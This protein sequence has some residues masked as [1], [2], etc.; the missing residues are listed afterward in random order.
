VTVFQIAVL[1]M[2]AAIAGR[3]SKGRQLILL[4]ISV[5]AVFWLQD[6][7]P[8]PALRFW[9]PLAT[10][11]L[12]TLS[13]ALTATPDVRSWSQNWPAATVLAATVL[14]VAV[15]RHIPLDR[16]HVAGTPSLAAAILAVIALA[17]T[18]ALLIYWQKAAAQLRVVAIIG[19]IAALVV[20]KSPAVM[21]ALMAM[22]ANERALNLTG[23]A[24][25]IAWLGYSY[26]AFRLLHTIRDRQSGRLPP[27]SLSE[28]VNYAVFFPAFTS[29]P[30]DRAERFVPE[31]RCPLPL[32][33]EDWIYAV[34]RLMLGLFKK[35]VIADLLAVISISNALVSRV[36]FRGMLWLF[37]Y[38][39]AFRIY[40]DFSGYTDIA[41]GMG[42]LMGIQ[43]P[44]NFNSPYLK[45]NLT[46][47][48]NAWHITL[49]QWFRSYVFNPMTRYLRRWELPAWLII[50]ITQL[51]TMVLIGL[52][53]GITWGFAAWGLWHG[54]GLFIHNRW[55]EVSRN[56]MPAWTRVGWGPHVMKATG[57]FLTFNYVALGWLFFTLSE[58]R[59]A[60]LAMRRLFGF[61]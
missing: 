13:W 4:A 1:A 26:L 59:V 42:R 31:L 18:T 56:R 32:G 19:I 23:E 29:G 49:T 20:L 47:F 11:G 33:S 5:I 35:F 14:S 52:W 34:R 9:L 39:Y 58:P 45:P 55:T 12:T 16:L 22:L 57:V 7:E 6:A 36:Q 15:L 38:A 37:L 8:Y 46:Q 30:I 60:W 10:V 44:E 48:W 54:T 24:M 2:L 50:L 27:V 25:V 3:I 28:Y 40:F 51:T 41:I 21:Q 61:G 53:H 43:L 17:A